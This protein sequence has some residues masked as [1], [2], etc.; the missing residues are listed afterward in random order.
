MSNNE[1]MVLGTEAFECGIQKRLIHAGKEPVDYVDGTKVYFHYKTLISEDGTVIDD[2]K[3]LNPNKPMELIIGKKFKLEVWER[4][5][6]TMWSY[7]V[8]KFTVVKEVFI[9]LF[10]NRI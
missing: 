8:A 4:A 5:I 7:E 6:K 3:K 9:Y 1:K 10:L 2:S